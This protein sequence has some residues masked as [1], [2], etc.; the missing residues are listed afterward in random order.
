M[1]R[2]TITTG[3]LAL[4]PGYAEAC[5]NK[6]LALLVTGDFKPGWELYE[7]RWKAETL[8]TVYERL[9]SQPLWL[10]KDPLAGKTILLHSEQGMG[11]T[12]QFC[13]YARLVAGLGARVILEIDASLVGLFQNLEGADLVI[14][15]G[16]PLPPFDCHCPLMSL[17]LAFR[18][19]L[20]TIPAAVPYLEV[21]KDRLAKWGARLGEKRAPRVGLVWSGRVLHKN[22]H[23][24]S[25]GL[26]ELISHLP[27]GCQY[28]SLQ[29][30]IRDMDRPVLA[31]HG[32]ILHFEDELVD[33]GDTAALCELMDVVV[34][35]DTSVAHLAG[36]LGRPV[37]I[38]LPYMPDWRWLLDRAD[39][40]WYP[41][42]RLYRQERTGEWSGV[43]ERVQADLLALAALAS[44]V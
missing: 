26:A 17:P 41:S 43:L 37:W 35:V 5:W 12:I 30:E 16:T 24:R 11:D 31:S 29:K 18:T 9:F 34:S 28:L 22:D 27:A 44:P 33:F 23:N 2:S 25:L 21:G 6:S 38:L 7:W 42:A 10:G 32:G 39:S 1:W 20:E 14:A 36:A 13:R 15:R 19:D 40:P 4:K 3:P 8:T